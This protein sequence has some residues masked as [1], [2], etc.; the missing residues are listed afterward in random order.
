MN[1]D[2]NLAILPILKEDTYDLV[3]EPHLTIMLFEKL[4]GLILRVGKHPWRIRVGD[5]NMLHDAADKRICIGIVV[6]L[7][8]Q[9]NDILLLV[10]QD[11][12]IIVP[13]KLTAEC[14]VAVVEGLDL[15]F[16]LCV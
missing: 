7:L 3:L 5:V 2:I 1:I 15:L 10:A 12:G 13:G 4:A 11:L 6:R 16:V 8:K 9:I 14:D